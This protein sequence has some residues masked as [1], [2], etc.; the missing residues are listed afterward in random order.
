M[1]QLCVFYHSTIG[2]KILM[3]VTGVILG[4]FLVGH[5][6]GNLLI[7]QGPEAFNHYAAF[8]QSKPL[9]IWTARIILLAS[10]LVHILMALQLAQTS[11]S[12]RPYPYVKQVTLES[13]Y[14]ARTMRWTGPLVALFIGYHLAHYTAKI[15]NPE[16]AAM[17][18]PDGTLDV[19][20]MVI[21][22]FSVPMVSFFYVASMLLLCLH[23]YH[24][25][26]SF[27]QTMGLNHPQY[28]TARRVVAAGASIILALGFLSI[29]VAVFAGIIK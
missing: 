27:F 22:A 8:L 9:M 12:A 25:F 4:G 23:L 14:A 16:F 19:Y 3:A 11:W 15:T 6:A 26:W 2:K 29:P 24:A 21:T 13:S 5:L 1:N 17:T 10:L 20:R 18:L 7:F 28:N